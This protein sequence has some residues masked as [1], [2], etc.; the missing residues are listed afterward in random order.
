MEI[1]LAAEKVFEIGS[2]PVTNTLLASW[3]SVAV[4][5]IVGLTLRAKKIKA[6]PRGLQNVIEWIVEIWLNLMDGVTQ[7]RKQSIR[8]FP[9]VVTIFLFVVTSNWLGIFPGFGT[10]GLNEMKHGQE[11][12]VP[13]F[14]TVNSD[15][16]TTLALA[17][18]SVIATQVFGILAVGVFKYWKRFINIKNPIIGLLE[19]IDQLATIVSFSFRLFGNIF[20]GEVLLVIISS[21][22]PYVVPLPFYFLELFVGLVQGFI[23]AILS[24]VFF[25]VA[26]LEQHE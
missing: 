8:F 25:K 13:F 3:I 12:F 18:I 20:A 11:V 2:L 22:I 7:D 23:F 10:I 14:R 16:N 15:L 21:L 17:I 4:L 19:F 24:L 26:T 6:V 1:S 9:W 5:V